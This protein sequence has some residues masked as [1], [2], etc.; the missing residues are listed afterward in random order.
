MKS[1]ILIAFGFVAVSVLLSAYYWELLPCRMPMH[2]NAAGVVD[3]WAPKH[4]A[5]IAFPALITFMALIYLAGFSVNHN[6]GYWKR[7]VRKPVSDEA[8]EILI[9]ESQKVIDFVF[10]VVLAMF[11]YLHEAVIRIALGR[12]Q[13]IVPGIWIFLGLLFAGLIYLGG[14]TIIL[15]YRLLK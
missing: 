15:Q 5:L 10:L 7:K 2:F 12:A 1:R 9:R 11:L 14:R 4:Q 13:T 3:G 8:L 6:R